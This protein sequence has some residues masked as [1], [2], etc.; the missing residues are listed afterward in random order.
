MSQKSIDLIGVG[1]PILDILAQVDEEFLINHVSGA[2]GGM[3]LVDSNSI[4]ELIGKISGPLVQAPGGSAANSIVGAQRLGLRTSFLGKVGNDATASF[5]EQ[6]FQNLGTDVSRL[7]RADV[8]NGRCLSLVTPDSQRT[9]RTDLGAAMTLQPSEVS[10]EDFADCRHAHIEGYQ[11]FNPLLMQ[12]ILASAKAAGCSISVDLASFEVVRA[13]AE[14]LP[15]ILKNDVTLVFANED[16]GAAL[17]GLK[18]DYE[19]M[20]LA[21]GQLCEIAVVK[22]GKEGAWIAN[23]GKL[24]RVQP[25][26]VEHAVDT[27][28]AGDLWAGGFLY[29]WLKGLPLEECGKIGSLLGAEVVQ[30]MGAAIPEERWEVIREK[31]K[32]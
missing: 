2:K 27:T 4:G 8:S 15:T 6:G 5:Y 25:I 24:I 31:L 17:T 23:K 9:M 19:G 12:Q 7:K 18:D 3:E 11:L 26:W 16:E 1:S 32:V 30:V 29:G 10:A 20:A 28:G 14:S 21:L 13:A 22:M